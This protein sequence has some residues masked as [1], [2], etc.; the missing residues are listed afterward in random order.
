MAIQR[1]WATYHHYLTPDDLDR[2]CADLETY[3]TRTALG[4][5]LIANEKD[6]RVPLFVYE[7]EQIYFR[8]K[9]DALYQNIEHPGIFLSR[10][11]KSSR[12]PKTEEEI[13]KDIQQW[14]YNYGLHEMFPEIESLT[15]LY[16]MLRY[17]VTPTRYRHT[18]QS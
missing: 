8:F 5:R 16:D 1:A 11:Y 12:W 7:G 9:V 4:Y 17:G 2:M 13:H 10:D 18:A 14:A 15:Q 3:H 6:M